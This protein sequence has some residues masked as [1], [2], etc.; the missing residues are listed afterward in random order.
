MILGLVKLRDGLRLP[1]ADVGIQLLLGEV[2]F[3]LLIV[4][5]PSVV[6]TSS[7]FI[8]AQLFIQ[9]PFTIQLVLVASISHLLLARDDMLC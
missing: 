6:T 1:K 8:D 9:L 4:Q 7:E 2:T 3:M 5:N